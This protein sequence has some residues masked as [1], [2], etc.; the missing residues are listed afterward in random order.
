MSALLTLTPNAL[1][2]LADLALRPCYSALRILHLNNSNL[3]THFGQDYPF[4]RL[5]RLTLIGAL[6]NDVVRLLGL[7]VSKLYA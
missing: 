3:S 5:T 1:A 2:P 7:N 6:H 4:F